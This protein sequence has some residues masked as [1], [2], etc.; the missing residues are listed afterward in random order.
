MPDVFLYAIADPD[1]TLSE[2]DAEIP[3]R[4]QI[5]VDDEVP[6]A[7]LAPAALDIFHSHV[8]VDVL[9]D[10]QFHVTDTAGHYLDGPDDDDFPEDYA[11]A[12]DG[13]VLGQ[14]IVGDVALP[15][16]PTADDTGITP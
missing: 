4:Y 3:G 5:R 11:Y 1:V 7:H 10:F 9:E 14:D 2:D 13:E 8:A 16:D 6:A 15:P 12:D